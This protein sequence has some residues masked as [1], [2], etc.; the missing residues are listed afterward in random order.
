[1]IIY[2][3]DQLTKY[4]YA[5]ECTSLGASLYENH[6]EYEV[7]ASHISYLRS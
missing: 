6:N 3:Y 4:I 2:S 7:R 5:L 1:M